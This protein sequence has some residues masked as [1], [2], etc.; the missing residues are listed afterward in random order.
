[1]CN[2]LR[3]SCPASD[4][5]FVSVCHET[6]WWHGSPGCVAKFPRCEPNFALYDILGFPMDE[7][8]VFETE[9]RYFEKFGTQVAIYKGKRFNEFGQ[10]P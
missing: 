6:C 5:H 9:G 2:E 10:C 3:T 4:G 1:M 8:A 7:G